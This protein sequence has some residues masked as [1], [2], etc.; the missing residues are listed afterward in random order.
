MQVAFA[1]WVILFVLFATIFQEPIKE[2]A[3]FSNFQIE[4]G[5]QTFDNCKLSQLLNT[6]EEF[7]K[8]YPHDK[9]LLEFLNKPFIIGVLILSFTFVTSRHSLKIYSKRNSVS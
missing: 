9:T 6:F 1:G 2:N 4:F 3:N 5:K 8:P 7:R